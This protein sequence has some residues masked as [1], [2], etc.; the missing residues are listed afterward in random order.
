VT[1]LSKKKKKKKGENRKAKKGTTSFKSSIKSTI[2][3]NLLF[4]L[5]SFCL[6]ILFLFFP[7]CEENIIHFDVTNNSAKQIK[8]KRQEKVFSL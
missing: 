2:R 1:N 7:V 8:K 4:L 3:I 5:L 6:C